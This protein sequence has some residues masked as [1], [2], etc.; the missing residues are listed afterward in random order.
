MATLESKALKTPPRARG[1]PLIGNVLAM[2]KDP[3]KF[4]V[5]CYRKYGPVYRVQ[6]F[7]NT[8]TVLAGAEAANF[9]GTR[10]GRDSLRKMS[11]KVAARAQ[12]PARRCGHARHAR[13]RWRA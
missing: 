10:Q 9:M 12:D 2:A 1:I 6:V 4:F 7:N 11:S 5:D 13:H 3:A 8:Y